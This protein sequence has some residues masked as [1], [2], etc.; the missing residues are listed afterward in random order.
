MGWIILIVNMLVAVVF[1]ILTAVIIMVLREVK[2]MHGLKI[3]ACSVIL[4]QGIIGVYKD[5][6][7]SWVVVLIG[8]IVLPYAIWQIPAV[9]KPLLKL[10]WKIYRK[11]NGLPEDEEEGKDD[12]SVSSKND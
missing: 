12:S 1:S 11:L 10:F 2:G 8:L 5:L 4:A 7:N 3:A 6:P 9:N